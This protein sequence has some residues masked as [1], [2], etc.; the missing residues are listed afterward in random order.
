MSEKPQTDEQNIKQEKISFSVEVEEIL[1]NKETIE[2]NPIRI[3]VQKKK[4][5]PNSEERL[6]NKDMNTI[7]Q[8]PN[9]TQL[10]IQLQF[11][12]KDIYK[13]PEEITSKL[14]IS[15]CIICQSQ[16]FSLY[17]PEPS[18]PVPTTE[19]EQNK[20]VEPQINKPTEMDT[21][22]VPNN[23][24]LF[25][26]LLICEQNHQ[27]C[28]VCHNNPHVNAFCSN[29]YMNNSNISLLYDI[30]KESVPEEKK[31][32]FN[33]MINK[34]LNYCQSQNKNSSNSCCTCK[35]TWGI[36]FLIFGLIFWTAASVALFVAGLG[37]I[38]LSLGLRLLSCIYH[39]CYDMC[40]T[41]EVKEY[42]KGDH[43]L[44]V[45]TTFVDREE[46][47]RR[48]AESDDD[49]LATCGAGGMY[50]AIVLI[51][52]GYKKVIEIYNKIRT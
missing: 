42:D 32:I 18:T 24:G 34:A 23:Q 1:D 10:Q 50:C 45:T 12:E 2:I 19:N 35:C 27:F 41:T 15:P 43:I 3:E 31:E 4:E 9:D 20:Q 29:E 30:L 49:C 48:E 25:L 39:C 47:N 28:L 5:I 52:E 22:K 26:P 37:F 36:I 46:A 21:I 17:I 40:C 14:N 33:Y 38:A 11:N 6:D 13:L 7:N 16:N 8:Q 44:R 51:P